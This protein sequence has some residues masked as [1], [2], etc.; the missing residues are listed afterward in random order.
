VTGL[1]FRLELLNAGKAGL[2]TVGE[3]VAELVR[4]HAQR[5]LKV[6]HRVLGDHA[7]LSSAQQYPDGGAVIRVP[8]DVI[9]SRQL[10]VQL[11]CELR[12][13]APEL[14]LDD[15]KAPEP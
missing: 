4:C 12:L 5:L 14:E 11:A 2:D 1:E 13:E 8:Q 15:H 3:S 7:V 6:A 9:G 10:E